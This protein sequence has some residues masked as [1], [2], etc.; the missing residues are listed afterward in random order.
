MT[1]RLRFFLRQRAARALAVL[2]LAATL[3]AL[4]GCYGNFPLTKAVY[5]FN[6]EVSDNKIVQSLI[7][8]VFIFLP[9]Y[10][11]AQL[12]DAIIFNLIEFW[13]GESLT[14]SS[15]ESDDGTRI[16][17][18][19]AENGESALLTFARPDGTSDSATLV[20]IDDSRMEMRD[21]RGALLGELRLSESGELTLHA[22][23]GEN[24]GTRD[25]AHLMPAAR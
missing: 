6:G 13:T 15:V 7:F 16:T 25:V 3:P 12:G 18:I 21:A 24:L 19:P 10:G 5:N 11:F 17:L 1:A 9:V 14:I 2:L 4:S 20:R 8:W 22:A 23:D